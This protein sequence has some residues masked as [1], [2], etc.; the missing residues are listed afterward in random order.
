ML[1]KKTAFGS[2]SKRRFDEKFSRE[3]FIISVVL[4]D[5]TAFL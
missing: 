2:L 4:H 3:F 5:E 1:N